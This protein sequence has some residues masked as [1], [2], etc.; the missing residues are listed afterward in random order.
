MNGKQAGIVVVVLITVGIALLIG[1]YSQHV[2]SLDKANGY[3]QRAE[4]AGAAD[5]MIYFT[6]KAQTLLEPYSGNPAWIFPTPSTN[7]TLIKQSL[8]TCKW[9]LKALSNL[10]ITSE[11][12][13]QGLDDIRG[14]LRTAESNLEDASWWVFVT[15]VNV[16]LLLIWIMAWIILLLKL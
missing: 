1:C 3:L 6:S 15:P 16:I 10:D 4:T 11:A 2:Y 14:K 13:Q 12:Y 8:E 7:I 9:R 5:E